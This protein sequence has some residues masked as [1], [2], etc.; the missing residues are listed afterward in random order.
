MSMN[1]IVPTVVKKEEDFG[2]SNE[3][4]PAGT[5]LISDDKSWYFKIADGIEAW[6]KLD[7]R[8]INSE[9]LTKWKAIAQGSIN[10]HLVTLPDLNFAYSVVDT[11]NV[12]DI[13][14]IV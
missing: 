4:Y 2:I 9:I 13:T 6:E 1:I 8:G 14:Q 7:K 10:S 5:I 11:N 3:I 12:S